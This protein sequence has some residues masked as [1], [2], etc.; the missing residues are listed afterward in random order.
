MRILTGLDL[1]NGRTKRIRLATI[2]SEKVDW[3]KLLGQDTKEPDVPQRRVRTLA[4]LN[5]W[6]SRIITR[7]QIGMAFDPLRRAVWS[8]PIV[9]NWSA[10]NWLTLEGEQTFKF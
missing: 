1:W 6:D 8:Y 10:G 9:T 7:N 3:S 4:S 2:A 5:L